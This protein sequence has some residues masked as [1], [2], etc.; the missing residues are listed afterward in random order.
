METLLHSG[1]NPRSFSTILIYIPKKNTKIRKEEDK[2]FE[3]IGIEH[4]D[5]DYDPMTWFK[6]IKG[7]EWEPEE[8]K[9]YTVF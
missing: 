7:L 3:K 4:V 2:R 5:V 6:R 9:V 1:I 8:G